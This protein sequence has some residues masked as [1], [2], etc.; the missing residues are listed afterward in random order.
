[1]KRNKNEGQRINDKKKKKK[2]RK[3]RKQKKLKK[4]KKPMVPS[5]VHNRFFCRLHC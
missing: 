5:K 4:K 2:E 3:K 1:M